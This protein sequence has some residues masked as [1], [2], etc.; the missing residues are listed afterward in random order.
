M[1][2]TFLGICYLQASQQVQ[3]FTASDQQ[4]HD[5]SCAVE[6]LWPIPRSQTC[7]KRFSAPVSSD[8]AQKMRVWHSK[9][10]CSPNSLGCKCVERVAKYQLPCLNADIDEAKH[11]LQED[12]S[13]VDME[14]MKFGFLS[15]FQK[16]DVRMVH[17][18]PLTVSTVFAQ[19]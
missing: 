5:E 2:A 18:T 13:S 8:A 4:S 12:F 19:V 9:E 3:L 6:V 10:N 17:I 16:L 1:G 14:C 7:D 11:E 15:F